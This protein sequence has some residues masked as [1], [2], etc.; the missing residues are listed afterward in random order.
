MRNIYLWIRFYVLY[1]VRY[2]RGCKTIAKHR[3]ADEAYARRNGLP[4]LRVYS[5]KIDVFT[6]LHCGA[7]GKCEFAWDYYNTDGDCLA[8]K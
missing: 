3:R 6:C 5:P 7:E 8:E 1:P 4:L 2:L